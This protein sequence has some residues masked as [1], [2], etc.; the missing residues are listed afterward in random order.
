MERSGWTLELEGEAIVCRRPDLDQLAARR[1]L[2]ELGVWM[3]AK[4]HAEA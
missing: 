4:E 3:L 2:E 1:Q